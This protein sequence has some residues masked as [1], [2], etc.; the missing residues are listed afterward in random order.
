MK[1]KMKS[2]KILIPALS[3]ISISL[4]ACSENNQNKNSSEVNNKIIF[5]KDANTLTKEKESIWFI[6]KQLQNVDNTQNTEDTDPYE[7]IGEIK[8]ENED[9]S[10]DWSLTE[11]GDVIYNET[12]YYKLYSNICSLE[13]PYS[14]NN[15]INFIIKNYNTNE[16]EV[17]TELNKY[18][19]INTNEQVAMLDGESSDNV[20][21]TIDDALINNADYK[22]MCD[23]YNDKA[24]WT[25]DVYTYGGK[26]KGT[27]AGCKSFILFINVSGDVIMDMSEYN[28]N[29]NQTQQGVE[30]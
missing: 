28:S 29:V 7:N 10:T 14:I 23:K 3:I 16:N 2:I 4:T 8:L 27:I 1:N 18:D 17:Y 22:L 13:S 11:N 26:N 6:D 19:T 12:T 24:T 15:L 5:E 21:M 25:L 20:D 9:T 30:E